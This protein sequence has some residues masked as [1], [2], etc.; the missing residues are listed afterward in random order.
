MSACRVRTAHRRVKRPVSPFSYKV[1]K[2]DTRS[3]RATISID[4]AP[5]PALATLGPP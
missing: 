3:Y 5:A 2:I 4:I 1:P